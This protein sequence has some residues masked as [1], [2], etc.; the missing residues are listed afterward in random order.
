MAR[1]P[2]SARAPVPGCVGLGYPLGRCTEASQ[3]WLCSFCRRSWSRQRLCQDGTGWGVP[4]HSLGAHVWLK[5]N[6]TELFMTS[7]ERLA[8]SIWLHAGNT[9]LWTVC[10]P[11]S[12]LPQSAVCL[13]IT[14]PGGFPPNRTFGHCQR[15]GNWGTGAGGWE[16]FT[17][18]ALDPMWP[19]SQGCQI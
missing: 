7:L 19:L 4:A 3:V 10:G 14:E 1:C 12:R 9:C 2:R 15:S 13:S 5:E 17:L 11:S 16:M 18:E 8:W 6:R